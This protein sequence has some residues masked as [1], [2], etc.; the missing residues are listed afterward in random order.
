MEQKS[1]GK[2]RIFEY[3]HTHL[4]RGA[5]RVNVPSVSAIEVLMQASL[6]LSGFLTSDAR[7]KP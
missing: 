7:T 2:T 4:L 1:D 6:F 3:I 5:R